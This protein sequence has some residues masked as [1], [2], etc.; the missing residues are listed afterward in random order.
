MLEQKTVARF[1]YLSQYIKPGVGCS[2]NFGC[3]Y[4]NNSVDI[5]SF[6]FNVAIILHG[7]RTTNIISSETVDNALVDLIS[8]D[9]NVVR[10]TSN[11][12]NHQHRQIW[13]C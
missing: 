12:L 3:S 9:Y 11:T 5:Q 4:C 2:I 7:F 10:V 1:M 13:D 8:F 6:D